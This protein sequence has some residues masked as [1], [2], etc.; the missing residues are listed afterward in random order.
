MGYLPDT[1]L[2]PISTHSNSHLVLQQLRLPFQCARPAAATV[3]TT[4]TSTTTTIPPRVACCRRCPAPPAHVSMLVLVLTAA[5]TDHAPWY[6]R[7]CR[8]VSTAAAAT[9]TIPTR[10]F[11]FISFYLEYKLL[12]MAGLKQRDSR[13][14]QPIHHR[15]NCLRCETEKGQRRRQRGARRD[16]CRGYMQGKHRQ[17]LN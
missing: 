10:V 16:M 5:A 6:Y 13:V 1:P 9:T 2:S 14:S 15:P 7:R 17:L 12:L 3:S 8:Y 11:F 4:G